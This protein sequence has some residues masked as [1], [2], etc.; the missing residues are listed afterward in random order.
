[1]SLRRPRHGTPRFPAVTALLGVPL[2]ALLVGVGGSGAL[3]AGDPAAP[4]A[5]VVAS[6]LAH[7][8]RSAARADLSLADRL[9]AAER[10][11]AVPT[12]GEA[13][14]WARA[15][16]ALLSADDE[17]RTG[18]RLLQRSI[19]EGRPEESLRRDVVAAL[20]KDQARRAGGAAA[21]A[22]ALR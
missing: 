11:L 15:G 2:V 12:G 18:P 22:A 9:A 3:E 17:G 16:L 21:E 8:L 20:A 19:L 7:H 10:A 4:S 14:A 5:A 13:R 6:D 1:M